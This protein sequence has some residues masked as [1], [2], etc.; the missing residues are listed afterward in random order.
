M[1]N[2]ALLWN[3]R[4]PPP[5]KPRPAEPLWSMRKPNG[6]TMDAFLRGQGEFGWECQFF[7]NGEFSQSRLWTTRAQALN[8]AEEKRRELEG[9]GWRD[10][11]A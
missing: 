1:T 11:S 9:E 5:R 2:P 8:Q 6:N 7:F 4:P 3:H 10:V